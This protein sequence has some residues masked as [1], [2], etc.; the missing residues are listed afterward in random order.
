MIFSAD[1]LVSFVNG[2]FLA[3]CADWRHVYGRAHLWLEV[4]ANWT[5]CAVDA[6][7]CVGDLPAICRQFRL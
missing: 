1:E 7:D 2:V 5:S 6:D 4:T 3:V